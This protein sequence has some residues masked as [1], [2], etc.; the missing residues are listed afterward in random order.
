MHA[1]LGYML[2]GPSRAACGVSPTTRRLIELE[3]GAIKT[4]DTATFYGD[5]LHDASA[6]YAI[7]KRSFMISPYLSNPIILG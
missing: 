3:P 2:V 4:K 6:S 1:N 5:F 7:F